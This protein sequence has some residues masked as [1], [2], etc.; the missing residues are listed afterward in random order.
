VLRQPNPN[1]YSRQTGHKERGNS[2]RIRKIVEDLPYTS[3][4]LES[5]IIHK[6]STITQEIKPGNVVFDAKSQARP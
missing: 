4:D 6:F 5:L 2:F 3:R 1:H